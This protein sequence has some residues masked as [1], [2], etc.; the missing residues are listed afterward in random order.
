MALF[1]R[2]TGRLD[3]YDRA[4]NGTRV[5]LSRK[6]KEMDKTLIALVVLAF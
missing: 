6:I 3:A 1:R 5:H 2:G 4:S